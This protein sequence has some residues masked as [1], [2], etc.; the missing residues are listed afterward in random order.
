MNWS[1]RRAALPDPPELADG[2]GA[3]VAVVVAVSAVAAPFW[4]PIINWRVFTFS[5]EPQRRLRRN[6]I[7]SGRQKPEWTTMITTLL[8][9][10][11]CSGL[12]LLLLLTSCYYPRRALRL[13][14]SQSAAA[15]RGGRYKPTTRLLLVLAAFLRPENLLSQANE[16][17]EESHTHTRTR[18]AQISHAQWIKY[19]S[20]GCG[21]CCCGRDEQTLFSSVCCAGQFERAGPSKRGFRCRAKRSEAFV[22]CY[23]SQLAVAVVVVGVAD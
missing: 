19:T 14:I 12:L 11:S 23:G 16:E 3:I 2:A 4:G 8:L 9:L 17:D 22:A 7:V 1:G 20:S 13:M 5:G 6:R 10:L 18:A 21:C 15:A